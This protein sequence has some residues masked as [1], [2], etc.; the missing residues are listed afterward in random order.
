MNQVGLIF[1]GQ[2]TQQIGM[3]QSLIEAYPF[4]K[5]LYQQAS[6]ILGYDLE[7]LCKEGPLEKLTESRYCQP[8]LF[9][10]QFVSAKVLEYLG[11]CE[12]IALAMGLSIGSL[13]ALTYAGVFDFETGLRIVQ[14]RGGFIQEACEQ[15]QGGM[16]SLLGVGEEAAKQLCQK[17]EVE[18]SNNNCPGQ[19]VIS[20][21]KERIKAAAQNI[22]SA[23]G[24]KA[25]VL[26]VAGAF[27]SSLMEPARVKF[28]QFLEKIPFK[29]PKITVVSNVTGQPVRDPEQIK[30]LL[31]EQITSPVLWWPCMET[32][33]SLGVK[34]FYECGSGRTLAGMAKRISGEIQVLSFGK[35]GD[36]VAFESV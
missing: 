19:I 15:T 10:H 33:L 29:N 18:L 7:Q 8:S 4:V 20:G 36:R 23:T 1:P 17:Y 30:V 2:G 24:G 16:A 22:P 31:A 35:I 34:H 21:E 9:V 5:N 25:I 3:G 32:A 12:S 27:H 13:T 14:K 26:N 11:K 6:E 28:A